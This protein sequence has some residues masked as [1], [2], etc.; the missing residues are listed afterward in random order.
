MRYQ[1]HADRLLSKVIKTAACWNWIGCLHPLGYGL[2]A[3]TE[4][5]RK[6]YARAHRLAYETFVGPIPAG[7][8]VCHTCDNRRCVNPDHLFAGT[9]AENMAD[10]K[11]K[12]R[13]ANIG[14]G[15]SNPR[16]RLNDRD[17]LAFRS[18]YQH[19]R[20][21]QKALALEYGVSQATVSRVIATW[22]FSE[23]NQ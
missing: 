6:K 11:S 22:T 21:T 9:H 8:S 3:W 20:G 12:G 14:G 4:G 17:V 18:A 10:M 15:S 7:Q 5:G 16:A 1:S 13:R 2:L 19:G 23:A